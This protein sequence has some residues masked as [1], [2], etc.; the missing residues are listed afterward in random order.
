[1]KYIKVFEGL[2]EIKDEILQ[3]I[4]DI[5]SPYK[6]DV[7]DM[8]SELADILALSGIKSP[9]V[10]SPYRVILYIKYK[11][12]GGRTKRYSVDVGGYERGIFGNTKSDIDFLRKLFIM[13]SLDGSS[14][15]LKI[16]RLFQ[17]ET[18]I[19]DWKSSK[20]DSL[21]KEI[22]SE[23]IDIRSRCESMNIDLSVDYVSSDLFLTFRQ[24]I[25]IDKF[26]INSDDDYNKYVPKNI[27]SDFNKFLN[28]N[29]I[30]LDDR[31]DLVNI[32]KRGDWSETT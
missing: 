30:K 25:P 12:K 9:D 1:M 3:K 8:L 11:D 28:Q 26:I 23:I 29:R 21:R 13:A 16:E 5:I 2:K 20:F 18:R 22:D 7:N 6:D 31:L 14:C 17:S 27:I 19:E 4:N 32:I 24:D 15:Y 10:S